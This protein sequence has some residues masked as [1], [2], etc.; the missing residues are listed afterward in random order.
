MELFHDTRLTKKTL[1]I[2]PI[3]FFAKKKCI[4]T[5]KYSAMFTR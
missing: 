5:K 1:L 3:T 2:L 4:V